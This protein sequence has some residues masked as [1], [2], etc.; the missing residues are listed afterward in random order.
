MDNISPALFADYITAERIDTVIALSLNVVYA[1]VILIVAS[2]WSWSII[3]QKLITYRSARREAQVFER[4]FWSGNPLDE[5]F[6]DIGPDPSGH[7]E[8]IFAAG[9][10]EWRRSHR[11]DGALIPGAQA[12][13]L[14]VV[15]PQRCA[16]YSRWCGNSG[17]TMPA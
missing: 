5:L 6:D 7:S 4:A 15:V 1:L 17:R 3:L 11:T 13:A 16:A 12:W 10:T 2:V 8:R 9:M 14:A